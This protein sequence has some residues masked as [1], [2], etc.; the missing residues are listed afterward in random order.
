MGQDAGLSE[1]QQRVE[2]VGPRFSEVAE[3]NRQRGERLAG[4]LDQV[5]QGVVNGRVEIKRLTREL[6][7]ARR[8]NAELHGLMQKL[9]DTADKVDGPGESVVLCDL[10]ARAARLRD[11]AIAMNGAANGA[12]NGAGNGVANGAGNGAAESGGESEW[13]P[14]PEEEAEDDG[15]P[16]LE[17]TEFSDEDG[18]RNGGAGGAA[19]AAAMVGR[20]V[21][22]ILKRVSIKTGR[23]REA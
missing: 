2:A 14:V 15:E 19:E 6:A 11:Q 9:L 17:L 22:D 1:L 5:E 21:Q 23:L 10:E 18:Q 13:E 12:A 8:E 3:D 16:P 4:L 20:P 7:D